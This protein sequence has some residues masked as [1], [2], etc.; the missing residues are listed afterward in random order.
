MHSPPTRNGSKTLCSKVSAT[1]EAREGP[2]WFAGRAQD[3]GSQR[4]VG[5]LWRDQDKPRA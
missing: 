5:G 1:E 3:S 2:P 4:A